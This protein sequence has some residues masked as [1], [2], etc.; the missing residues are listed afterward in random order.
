MHIGSSKVI[1][2]LPHTVEGQQ[3]LDQF[4]LL[5]CNIFSRAPYIEFSHPLH[6]QFWNFRSLLYSLHGI[7]VTRCESAKEQKFQQL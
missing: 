4:I 1:I 6:T 7:T 3:S 2:S 5:Y